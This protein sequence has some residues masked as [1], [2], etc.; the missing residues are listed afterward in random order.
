MIQKESI[1]TAI[2]FAEM[3]AANNQVV[4]AKPS[5]VVAELVK[6]TNEDILANGE[7]FDAQ[8]FASDVEHITSGGLE[9][10]SQHDL[11]SDEVIDQISKAVLNHI[12]FAKNIVKP[13]VVDYAEGVMQYLQNFQYPSACDQFNIVV[14]DLPEL[15]EDESFVDSLKKYVGKTILKPET[16]PSLGRKAPEDLL[17]MMLIGDREAD[18]AIT[19]WYS[20]LGNDFFMNLW[21][22]LF[23][24]E[25]PDRAILSYVGYDEILSFDVFERS[26]YALALYLL[27]NKLFD[28]VDEGVEGVN[29]NAYRNIIAETRDFAASVLTNIVARVEGFEKTKLLVISNDS[30]K[31]Q[32]KVYGKVYRNWLASGG[33]VETILGLIVSNRAVTTQV[34]VDEIRPYL[35]ETW[36]THSAFFTAAE[37]N[38]RFDY[39]K[40]ALV[41]KFKEIMQNLSAEE[42]EFTD[43]TTDYMIAVD[44][45]FVEEL[46]KLRSVDMGDLYSVA[47]KLVC[48]AR[49][50]YTD[51]E[52]I[53]SDIVEIAKINPD[54]DVREAALV[55]TINYVADYVAAQMSVVN[56]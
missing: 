4:V 10:P 3:L 15:L 51:A 46:N 43:S 23:R 21:E 14:A 29:L 28:V 6:R 9:A 18:Q 55:A 31:Q 40:D 45:R 13:L 17:A 44:R 5:T 7:N 48:R 11:F 2:G 52:R 53:L 25:Q 16:M 24:A 41:V 20:R 42:R 34:A 56:V 54:V 19:A 35:L 1:L 27:A 38:K 33:C 8:I 49:F 30:V 50:Y 22:N 37:S 47:L 32:A 12:N 39:F 26:D 36:K